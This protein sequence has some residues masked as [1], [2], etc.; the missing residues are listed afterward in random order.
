MYIKILSSILKSIA[1]DIK[2]LG[3]KIYKGEFP[4]VIMFD[5]T[6]IYQMGMAKITVAIK[7]EIK[8]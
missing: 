3:I 6:I 4:N 7:I 5:L 2:R 1:Q 8:L